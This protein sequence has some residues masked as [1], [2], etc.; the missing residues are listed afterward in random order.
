VVSTAWLSVIG[1]AA[2]ALWM[3]LVRASVPLFDREAILTR[4]R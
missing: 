3:V 2:L 4:W 1:A